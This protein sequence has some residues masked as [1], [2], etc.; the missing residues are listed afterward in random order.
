LIEKIPNQR[1]TCKKRE[2]SGFE[3]IEIN[4]Q[5]E[6]NKILMVN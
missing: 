2:T 4:G 5:I 1:P 3:I 6:K